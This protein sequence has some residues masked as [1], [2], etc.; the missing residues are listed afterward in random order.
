MQTATQ[1]KWGGGGTCSKAK[2]QDNALKEELSEVEMGKLPEK[3]L[4]VMTVKLIKE[5]RRSVVIQGP[6]GQKSK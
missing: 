5:L 6:Q 4:R 1:A 3:E 2:D